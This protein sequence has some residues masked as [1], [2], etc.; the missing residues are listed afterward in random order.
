MAF[1]ETLLEWGLNP[2]SIFAGAI[3]GLIAIVMNENEFSFKRAVA[4]LLCALACSGWGTDW[5]I[6]WLNWEEKISYIGMVGL[7][8]GLCGISIAK[9]F[10]LIGKQFETNPL[11]YIKFKKNDTN[12]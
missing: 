5:L 7:F 12:D 9:G 10:M 11:Q 1:K 8:L 6:V 2:I 3:G 4:Q